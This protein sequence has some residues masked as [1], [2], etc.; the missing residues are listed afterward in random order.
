MFGILLFRFVLNTGFVL[1][2]ISLV[3]PPSLAVLQLLLHGSL[4][5]NPE[6]TMIIMMSRSE[7]S[8]VILGCQKSS[9]RSSRY[10]YGIFHD[11]ISF[12]FLSLTFLFATY[13]A[14]GDP[15]V[16]D[17]S[18]FW[19]LGFSHPSFSFGCAFSVRRGGQVL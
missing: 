10:N 11:S 15:C 5:P 13:Q 6:L 14:Y 2:S 12:C 1:V 9:Q 7:C 4:N 8:L 18:L 17:L 3:I 19:H 16:W